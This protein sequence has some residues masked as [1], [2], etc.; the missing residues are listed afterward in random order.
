MKDDLNKY[1]NSGYYNYSNL[2]SIN[3]GASNSS[4]YLENTMGTLDAK[5]ADSDDE[6]EGLWLVKYEG[7]KIVQ[8]QSNST[9]LGSSDEDDFIQQEN[10][11]RAVLNSL[12]PVIMLPAEEWASFSKGLNSTSTST[13][14][15]RF[16]CDPYKCTLNPNI[17]N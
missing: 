11:T 5:S 7:S 3:F 2:P 15:H 9:M 4:D 17:A 14:A 10:A 16:W 1:E 8:P 6:D 13:Y 12:S